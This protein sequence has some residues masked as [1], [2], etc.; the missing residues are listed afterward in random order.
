MNNNLHVT[1]EEKVYLRELAKKHHGYANAPIMEERRK[2]WYKHNALQGE[3]PMVVMEH[4]GFQQDIMPP[5]RCLSPV[6]VMIE[7]Q[8]L[9]AII[10]YEM[11]NDDKVISPFFTVYWQISFSLFD[12]TIE[13]KHAADS[14][15][16]ERGYGWE[17]PISDLAH[18]LPTLKPSTWQVD[19]EQT[20]ATKVA[21]EEIIGDIMPVKIK[22]NTLQWFFGLSCS[23]VKLMGMENMLFAM[24]DT[25]AEF[26]ELMS[27][28]ANDHLAFVRWQEQEDLLTL[29]NENDY[30][31]A[32]SFGF[33]NELPT[34]EC[35]AS[36]NVTMKDLWLNTNSQESVGISPDMYEALIFPH[37]IDIAEHFGLVYYGCCEPV[38]DI[39][40][41]CISQLPNLRKVSVSAWCNEEIIGPK[42]AGS[43]VIYSRKPSPNFIAVDQVFNETVFSDH[44]AHTLKSAK[45]CTL[46][47][48]FRDIMTLVGD[49][50]RPGKAVQIVRDQIDKLWGK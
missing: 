26:T 43:N 12:M 15:G 32:G 11:I 49:R 18:G 35:K 27:R 2:L 22:N 6:A 39:W 24:L 48:I 46:E 23:V 21:V 29:N 36:G 3:R 47:I 25:P 7:T 17:P 40:D 8:L 37:Y 4:G 30:A 1:T 5:L 16:R 31:G 28:I 42:L 50:T 44:I 41:S 33:T 45:G 14:D 34:A 9:M 13:L 38:H 20:L 19:R 10:N